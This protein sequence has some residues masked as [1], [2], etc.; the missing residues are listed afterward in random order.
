MYVMKNFVIMYQGKQLNV[1]TKSSFISAIFT[2]VF[3]N[4]KTTNIAANKNTV[5]HSIFVSILFS[6]LFA[7]DEHHKFKTL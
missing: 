2:T 6:L 5:N 4:Y 1:R 7:N 3:S